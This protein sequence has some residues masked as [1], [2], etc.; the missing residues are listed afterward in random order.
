MV[1]KAW[2]KQIPK[3]NHPPP[4]S[5]SDFLVLQTSRGS[6]PVKQTCRKGVGQQ[7]HINLI[8]DLEYNS[9]PLQP[10]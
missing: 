8:L 7:M 1:Y 10:S 5:S 4:M 2:I 6:I 9:P 3:E